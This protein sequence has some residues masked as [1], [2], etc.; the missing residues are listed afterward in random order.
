MLRFRSLSIAFL[1]FSRTLCAQQADTLSAAQALSVKYVPVVAPA[2]QVYLPGAVAVPARTADVLR[3]FTGVQV[4]D[5]G[6]VGGLKTVN[7]RSLGSEHAGIFLDGI[8]ID[9]AQNMQVDLGRLSTDG[10]GSI[11]LYN[12]AKTSRLQTAKS[13]AAGAAVYLETDRSPCRE[14]RL[15]LQG[16]SFGTFNPSVQ[17]YRRIGRV[18]LR[19]GAEFLTS[20]GRY[21]FPF[22]D[23]TLAR[24]NG[25]IKSL[26][27]EAR[28]D[29][30]T[31]NG[32]WR[33]HAYSYGS[34]RGFPGPV[35]RRGAGLPFSAERQ[36][37]QDFF[38]QGIWQEEWTERWAT[39]LR[40][41][42]AD[43]YT[44][45]DTHPERNPMALP[46]N[47]HYRQRSG[48]LSVAQSFNVTG[49]WS[50][51]ASADVQYNTLDADVGQFVSPD[52]FTF[53]GALATRLIL[54]KFRAAAHLVWQGAQDRFDH[55]QAGGW[56]RKNSFRDAW[57][58]SSSMSWQPC[59]ALELS[60]FVKRIFRLPSFND[61]Y[62][63]QMGNASLAPESAFQTGAD[64]RHDGRM[65]SCL[66]WEVR[67]SPYFN[68]VSDKIVAIPTVS[69]FR[70]TML[71]IGRADIAGLDA[72][73]DVGFCRSGWSA[74]LTLRYSL[75]QALDHSIPGSATWGNQLPYIPRHSGGADLSL[76]RAGWTLCW[77]ASLVGGRWSRTA[78]IPDYH[79]A[80]WTLS[81]V[82]LE[83]K[84]VAAFLQHGGTVPEL[85]AGVTVDNVFD[86]P[87]QVVQG[88][89]MPG[90]SCMLSLILEW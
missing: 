72:K 30:E 10:L 36:A 31:R 53:A 70:W 87:Y 54:G 79:I 51:D 27:L 32:T 84:I 85:K 52:R 12:G 6:G 88:Y 16:G 25:D 7:V 14:W 57:M 73:A 50:V 67:I 69:Q 38:I 71:N 55:P 58:P 28:L 43:N 39:A 74:G 33:L 13:Y 64:L 15:R 3:R 40:C 22:Y 61:L 17:W 77:T 9:N 56:S 60:A 23:T 65:G 62:Y 11:A 63:T 78:N 76:S 47:L 5:Y 86:T 21:R 29:G 83:K 42:Y 24:E 35:I 81:T 1:L 4:K 89:P 44:H 2:E 26:R 18:T 48:Y 49:T 46:Y 19:T 37:D 68:R 20:D 34:E 41:K 45:Y 90:R 75:Q 59:R 66:T 8:Q 82:S 80:P